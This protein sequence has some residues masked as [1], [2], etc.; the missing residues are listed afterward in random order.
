MTRLYIRLWV[1]LALGWTV[2]TA[3]AAVWAQAP[4]GISFSG[5]LT[6]PQGEPRE[7]PFPMTFRI[8]SSPLGGPPLYTLTVPSVVVRK[9]QF[10]VLLGPF[11]PGVF[12]QG[13][14]ERYVEVQVGGEPPL[15]PRQLLVSFPFALN[16]LRALQVA[17]LDG[18]QG[19]AINGGLTVSGNVGIGTT[20]PASA[21]HLAGTRAL[22][23]GATGPGLYESFFQEDS[24]NQNLIIR[25]KTATDDY[26]EFIGFG[27]FDNGMLKIRTG[28]GGNEPIVFAQMNGQ[29]ENERM[30]IDPA[31][32]VGIGTANPQASLDVNGRI[33]RNGQPFSAAGFVS[34]GQRVTVPWGTVDHWNI[35]VSPR[36]LGSDEPGSEQDNALLVIRV[37][38][39]AISNTTWEIT[40]MCRYRYTASSG[41]WIAGS[42]NYMLIPK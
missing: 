24:P 27:T 40:A 26:F 7:G 12:V 3:P 36:E 18:A 42:A 32:N 4:N 34:H 22:T 2:G 25:G 11:L 41:Q 13:S 35:F 17:S 16:A 5:T 29:T 28:D 39:T 33:L 20:S 9:G 8:F 6:D 30:R 15:I 19:G 14:G 21:L 38:A 1:L 31:G 23:I 37:F 10:S